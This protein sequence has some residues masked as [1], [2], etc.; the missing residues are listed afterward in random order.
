MEACVRLFNSSSTTSTAHILNRCFFTRT[1]T[2]TTTTA[3]S[4]HYLKF[5]LANNVVSHCTARIQYSSI[6]PTTPPQNPI[7]FFLSLSHSKLFNTSQFA[8]NVHSTT[9]FRPD[10]NVAGFTWNPAPRGVIDG[11]G[12]NVTGFG[13]Q[14]KAL[15]V[16]LL[17]WMGAKTKHLK[18][19]VEWYNSK[20]INAITFVVD[21][22]EVLWFD[23]GRNADTRISDLRDMIANWVSEKEE[24]GR[25]RCLLFHT[26]S[27]TG[28]FVCGTI[29]DGFQGRQ[30][31]M[32][33]IKG[34]VVDSG[35]VELLNPK[36]WAG[37]F[38]AAILKKRSSSAFSPAESINGFEIGEVSASKTKEK[39]PQMVETMVFSVLEKVFTSMVNSPAMN[40]RLTKILSIRTSDQLSCPWLHLYSRGDT[41]V[42]YKSIESLVEEQRKLGK[43]VFNYDFRLSPHV[44]HFRNFREKYT[45]ELQKFLKE[46]FATVKQT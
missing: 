2:T 4:T 5:P 40:R 20:G 46:C 37:G 34:F 27:N 22:R 21:V 3:I 26:F 9:P 6:S 43:R 11:G 36:V 25:E 19:Y 16:V 10:P 15:T 35:G 8:A 28:W 24:D 38:S 1:A 30:D 17:G 45:S 7:K 44:D 13:D 31:L 18:R 32:D 14:G 41:V 12:G 33:K 39:E 42:P 23:L 29:L